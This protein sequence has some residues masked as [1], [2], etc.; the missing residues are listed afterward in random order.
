MKC[1]SAI[2]SL[3]KKLRV[4]SPN[5]PP[6][7]GTDAQT[8]KRHTIVINTDYLHTL[9]ITPR[10]GLVALELLWLKIRRNYYTNI[11]F[12]IYLSKYN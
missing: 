7:N 9:C 6:C 10:T 12:F 3:V 2:N 5:P 1:F 11:Y 8:D 4:C